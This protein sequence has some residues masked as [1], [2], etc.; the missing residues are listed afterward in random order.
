MGCSRWKLGGNGGSW[1]AADMRDVGGTGV[2]E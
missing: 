1:G 2:V